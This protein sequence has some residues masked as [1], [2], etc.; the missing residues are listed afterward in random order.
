MERMGARSGRDGSA[1]WKGWERAVERMG[2]LSGKDGSAQRKGWERP[3]DFNGCFQ[4]KSNRVLPATRL[5]F[6]GVSQVA[7]VV[8]VV[9]NVFVCMTGRKFFGEHSRP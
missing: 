6:P 2:A 9:F 5:V 1:Q 7:Y 4:W 8:Y 3:V